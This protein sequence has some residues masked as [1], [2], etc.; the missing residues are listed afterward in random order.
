M[1][2]KACQPRAENIGVK[3]EVSNS[4]NIKQ[5]PETID[6]IFDDGFLV[7][8]G[9]VTNAE[10]TALKGDV[11]LEYE[12]EGKNHEN[13][14]TFNV[15]NS[16]DPEEA[17]H[18]S[19]HALAAKDYITQC[20][21]SNDSVSPPTLK[22]TVTQ[23]SK[24]SGVIS[25][26]TSYVAVDGST[27]V[28]VQG[29]LICHD[30]NDPMDVS[31]RSRSRSQRRSRSRSRS[32]LQRR[33]RSRSQ[34]RSRSRSRTRSR[35]GSRSRSRSPYKPRSRG[36]YHASRSPS[37]YQPRSR[38]C[39]RALHRSPELELAYQPRFRAR[40]RSPERSQCRDQARF[41][42]RASPCYYPTS[43]GN[44]SPPGYSPATYSRNSVSKH[45]G[46]ID[47][48]SVSGNWALTKEFSAVLGKKRKDFLLALPQSLSTVSSEVCEKESV[49]ATVLAVIWLKSQEFQSVQ[50]ELR[51]IIEKAEKWLLSHLPAGVTRD[52]L[53][54]DARNVLA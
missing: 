34:S 13:K 5:I 24:T 20:N 44:Y 19:L 18:F 31:S 40:D 1:L 21:Q 41:Y 7:V 46:L 38:E 28:P 50:D 53:A 36:L 42:F 35:S 54:Q 14:L 39:K 11:I 26:Y 22:D 33:P 10:A 25:K 3:W 27:Q 32:R 23:L 8:Y 4:L 9:V 12:V 37:P 29:P 6:F 43:P 45:I 2:E 17:R 52:E 47:L 30:A 48:Q 16:D 51:M 49:W 15:N